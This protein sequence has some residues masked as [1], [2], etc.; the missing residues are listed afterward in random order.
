MEIKTINPIILDGKCVA[1]KNLQSNNDSETGVSE[2]SYFDVGNPFSQST[3][4]NDLSKPKP[5]KKPK[6]PGK[7]MNPIASIETY[8]KPKYP[9]SQNQYGQG[10][11][12][13]KSITIPNNEDLQPVKVTEPKKANW[14]SKQ[15][16]NN[17]IMIA[18]VGLITV[19][20]IIYFMTKKKK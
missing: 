19:A 6:Y 17:K 18:S 14:W 8:G 20:S 9:L 2:F 11:F 15:T 12:T 16:K 13:P 5:Y 1:N 10:Y 4:L 3:P 7:P